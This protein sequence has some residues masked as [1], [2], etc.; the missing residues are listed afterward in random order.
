VILHGS[1]CVV[2]LVTPVQGHILCLPSSLCVDVRKHL[3]LSGRGGKTSQRRAEQYHIS[4][5]VASGLF[6]PVPVVL[7]WSTTWV[8]TNLRIREGFGGLRARQR[9]STCPGEHDMYCAGL[10]L[11]CM[12]AYMH[13]CFDL[14]SIVRLVCDLLS[15]MGLYSDMS[16]KVGSHRSGVL[17]WW[18]WYRLRESPS[19]IW[20]YS[21]RLK[22]TTLRVF[23]H[24]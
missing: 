7:F 9:C 2:W 14:F 15:R 12:R 6:I 8:W 20:I 1:V 17:C 11:L 19:R 24:T 10:V 4:L 3:L 21:T 13:L 23:S 22:R 5:W 16:W 18:T